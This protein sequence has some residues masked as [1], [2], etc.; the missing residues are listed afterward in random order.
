[1]F[2]YPETER[3]IVNEKKK[4]RVFL[5]TSFQGG[6]G[7]SSASLHFAQ[8]LRKKTGSKVALIELNLFSPSYLIWHYD[9]M[10]SLKTNFLEFFMGDWANF[11]PSEI[12]E[13]FNEV[14]GIFPIPF[15]GT[16]DK[17]TLIPRFTFNEGEILAALDRLIS[18]FTQQE[19]FVV[20]DLPM[21]FSPIPRY[22]LQRAD[23]VYYLFSSEPPSPQFAKHFAWEVRSD[24]HLW[25]K[26][27]FLRNYVDA[28]SESNEVRLFDRESPI[29]ILENL[30]E[31]GGDKALIRVFQEIIEKACELPAMSG[32]ISSGKTRDDPEPIQEHPALKDYTN[33]LRSEVVANLEKRFGLSDAELRKKVERYI[34]MAFDRTP[35]VEIPGRNCRSEIRKFLI[36][37]ILGLGPLEDF[38]RDSDVDEIMV[39]GPGK[40]FLDRHGK[41]TLT[42][43]T[44]HSADQVKAVIDR[45]LMPVGRTVNERTPFVDARLADG[46]RV[47]A[48]IPPLSLTG[49]MLTIRRFSKIPYSMEDLIYRFKTLPTNV[50]EF[51]ELC[52]RM[53]KNII[54]SGG[55]S[56]GKTTLLN[57]LSN[58]IQADERVISIE[59]SAELRLNQE[60][61]GRLESRNLGSEGKNQINIR[62]L[63]RNALRMRPDRIIVGECRG[64]EA[65]DMLQAMNT[66]HDGSLTTLHANTSRDALARLETMVLMA[67]VDLPLRA[68]REQIAGAVNIIIQAN[69]LADGSRKILEVVEVTGIEDNVI[70]TEIIFRF[71]KKWIGEDGTVFGEI[72]PTGVVP[73]FILNTPGNLAEKVANLFQSKALPPKE[74]NS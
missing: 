10:N 14:D 21:A 43:R 3:G 29:P 33:N 45:I 36:D 22:L 7:K 58:Y 28:E 1:M 42:G 48:I 59:D 41:L 74:A 73:H 15:C 6:V 11:A 38:M 46:S 31:E 63:V 32:T 49:P 68:I 47:H 69:R 35:P 53:R 51:L 54:V 30:S 23:V 13:R 20:V 34:D 62:E 37:E 18:V 70:Q 50:A 65:L 61:L 44:F 19:M 25:E 16:R 71:E 60:N 2:E 52:V 8:G 17:E 5:F 26:V 4:A 67:G 55:A 72:V 9:L 64:A 39:N 12:G 66:G 57:V 27:H 56:S 24:P 40:I